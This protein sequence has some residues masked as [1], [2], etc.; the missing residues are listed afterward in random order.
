V[1]DNNLLISRVNWWKTRRRC[2]CQKVYAIV[3][4]IAENKF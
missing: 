2:S 1:I 3:P 4:S